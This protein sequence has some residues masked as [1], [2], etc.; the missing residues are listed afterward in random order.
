MARLVAAVLL[1]ALLAALAPPP[2]RAAESCGDAPFSTVPALRTLSAHLAAAAP[3]KILAIGSS[4]TEGV[5]AS[6]PAR[7]YPAQLETR[8]R[9]AWPDETLDVV[10]AGIGGETADETMGRLERAMAAPARP[11]L[12]L[13]QVGTNDAVRGLDEAAF[14]DMVRR[15]VA[16]V[17]RAGVELVLIDQQ[18]FPR[19]ADVARYERYV[20]AVAEVGAAAGVAVFSRY[21]MMRAWADQD[22]ALIVGMLAPDG[23]HMSDRG[24]DCLAGALSNNLID[25]VESGSPGLAMA[26]GRKVVPTLASNR[27]G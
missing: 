12:V 8:L 18:F 5:G 23:F 11:D 19:I 4:S 10:N 9:A 1:P 13:W 3:A 15:G 16:L 7:S 6:A 27:K 21:G 17:R 24:Y 22:P 25:A 2:A 20:T 14:R 26:R